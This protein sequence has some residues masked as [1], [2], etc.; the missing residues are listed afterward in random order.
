MSL[1]GRLGGLPCP[2]PEVPC[3]DGG[4]YSDGEACT[5]WEAILRPEPAEQGGQAGPS[6][7]RRLL[8]HDCAYRPDSPERTASDG[9][10][11]DSYLDRPFYCH[12]GMPRAVGYTHPDL[13]GLCLRADAFESLSGDYQP[14]IVG[15]RPVRADGRPGIIC[16]GWAAVTGVRRA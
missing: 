1:H 2:D 15:G 12:D 16:A 11:P 5:R 3:C 14:L 10:L 7:L 8:C 9:D 13:P 6:P 4:V